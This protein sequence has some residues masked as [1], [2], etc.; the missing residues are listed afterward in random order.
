MLAVD[1]FHV[2]CAVTLQR[3]YVLFALEVGDRYL[4]RGAQLLHQRA[5][6]P[7][8]AGVHT[9][10]GADPVVPLLVLGDAV[11]PMDTPQL[12]HRAVRAALMPV[13]SELSMPRDDCDDREAA[14][15]GTKR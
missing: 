10:C 5:D 1:F 8:V 3:L 11:A 15:R 6:Q 9:I 14:A 12:R 7:A 4:L 13:R 2:D